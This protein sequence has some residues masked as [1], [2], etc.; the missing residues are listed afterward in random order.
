MAKIDYSKELC[1]RLFKDANNPA[2][3][4]GHRITR[5]ETGDELKIDLQGVH[6]ATEGSG[7]LV[8]DKFLGGGFAGQVYRCRLSELALPDGETIEGLEA[9]KLYAIK[10]I[11][12]PS[13]FSHRFR[14][15]IYWLAFQGPFSSQVN[16]GACRSGLILQKLVRRA[17]KI[18]FG[19]ET[20]IKDAYASFWD[21]NLNA[22]GEITEWIEGRM[23]QLE[24]DD[25]LKGRKDWKTVELSETGSP[26]YIAKRRFMADM[27]SMMHEMG[28]PEFARQY[29]WWTMKSQPNSMKRTDIPDVE[30]PGDG[31]CAIDFRAGLALLPWLPMSPGDI[32]L[33]F[34]GL[35]R[36]SLVQFD[37][38]D[39]E[40][41]K[42]F[43]EAHSETFGDLQPAIDEFFVKDREYRR[44]LPDITH[45]G[46]RVLFD[47]E[48]QNDIRIG[49]VEGYLAADLIDEAF[50]H[51]LNEGGL[52]FSMFHLLG[53]L[54]I[55]GKMIRKRWGN[56][57]YREHVF[58]ILTKPTYFKAALHAH[59]ANKLIAWHRAGR[60]DEKHI[61]FLMNWTQLDEVE[62]T[63]LRSGSAGGVALPVDATG[64]G[65]SLSQR[66]SIFRGE[67]A[68]ALP[69]P[70]LFLAEKFT[71]G[72]L[73]I[74]LH[75]VALRPTRVLDRIRDGYRFLKNFITCPDFREQWFL[76]E[77]AL[78]E[79]EGM[80]TAEERAELEGVVKDPFIV[81]Y[82]KCLGVH[83]ATVPITQIV[84][85][86]VGAVWAVW[87]LTHGHSWGEAIGAFGLTVAVFQV[88]PIS[89]GS[90]CRGGFVVY[91]MIKE[92]NLRDYIIAAPVSFLKY[93]G[94]LA[95]PLQ[96]TTT[97]PNLA[98]FMASR[99]ATQMVHIIPVF[100]EQGALLEHW[101]FD[102]FF[103]RPQKFAK[104]A[105][106]R[107][108]GLLLGWMI[109]GLGFAGLIFA[110]FP[111]SHA[112]KPM[113][114]ITLA[115]LVL[116][117]LP[118]WLFYPLMTKQK[119]VAAEDAK[120]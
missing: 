11:I 17:A 16:H 95:F 29:E 90:I 21:K 108:K 40:K 19:R 56:Q 55:L 8:V 64:S 65:V 7:T 115:T 102:L 47:R 99:W 13:T 92:R 9:G 109:F 25:E 4:I 2:L 76:N 15:T 23:W 34:S 54:P 68:A 35:K 53:T 10:I 42:A 48:L 38:C 77:I 86:L 87:L 51:K 63:L 110:I 104:W 118:R 97:Y 105:K 30:G 12:P 114:N 18:K 93:I 20:A 46:L 113:V 62:A 26:E 91:L 1:A 5:Y 49:L 72:I 24:A 117:V 43:F 50:A 96:M 98:R 80:L 39:T 70:L 82:L 116:F 106:P 107:A 89:P 61:Q 88:I 32:K 85:V 81:R 119:H 100:G 22:Y 79:K 52:R 37:R 74:A 3:K 57:A 75:R 71:L 120:L 41:M 36:K 111:G 84:S 67:R 69:H 33:I 31:L 58:S 14:N 59:A 94:Y 112:L 83:F 73:P 66:P 27:V 45:H 44:S 78:G 28:A 60:V 103:N 6:P 101:I